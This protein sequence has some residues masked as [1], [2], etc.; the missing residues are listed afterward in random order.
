MMELKSQ[1]LHLEA[2]ARDEIAAQRRLGDQIAMQEAALRAGDLAAFEAATILVQNEAETGAERHARRD[3]LVAALARHFGVSTRHVTLASV[4][5]R[6]GPD[7]GNLPELRRELRTV[8][9]DV[10]RDSRRLRRVM[11]ALREV[12]RELLGSLLGAPGTHALDN[13]G[14]L[15]NAEA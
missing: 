3:R 14:S 12:N 9:Q 10:A 1:L 8:A 6:A 15:V 13:E 7:A 5:E 4:I 2:W 11:V